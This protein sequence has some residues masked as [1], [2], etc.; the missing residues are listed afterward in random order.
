M[1]KQKYNIEFIF[2]EY[3]KANFLP[4]GDYLSEIVIPNLLKAFSF[5]IKCGYFFNGKLPYS[6][7]S[8][9]DEL[10]NTA[11]QQF[12]EKDKISKI[13]E[14][15]N[16]REVERLEA[17]ENPEAYF[18]KVI[19]NLII[20]HI[21]KEIPRGLREVLKNTKNYAD[22]QSLIS[23]DKFQIDEELLTEIGNIESS[24][25]IG[26][27][28][29]E[30]EKGNH[31]ND[32]DIIKN[33]F[34]EEFD[35]SFR[36][37]SPDELCL[38]PYIN[39]ELGNI[40]K[41]NLYYEKA[42]KFAKKFL[43]QLTEDE[44]NTFFYSLISLKEKKLDKFIN[45]I[46]WIKKDK[47]LDELILLNKN[48]CVDMTKVVSLFAPKIPHKRTIAYR[49]NSIWKKYRRFRELC[50]SHTGFLSNKSGVN[51]KLITEF[52]KHLFILLY[53]KYVDKNEFSEKEKSMV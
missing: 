48:Y 52:W 34:I 46:H 16:P 2:S 17:I 25:S 51:E 23:E 8:L 36:A 24:I 26:E 27:D 21:D 6:L 4:L 42:L 14:R 41:N 22:L 38:D 50:L 53:E 32:R 1:S 20:D 11:F 7:E 37:I 10:T 5:R 35:Y 12:I 40:E 28:Q 18:H 30:F 47:S 19:R 29:S 49:L 31:F 44:R 33:D 43:I 3:E 13:K 9:A 39:L 15:Y 45:L